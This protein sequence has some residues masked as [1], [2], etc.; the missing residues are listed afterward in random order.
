MLD[1]GFPVR[2]DPSVPWISARVLEPVGVLAHAFTSRRGGTSGGAWASLNL[3]LATGD[4]R[5]TVERNRSRLWEVLRLPRPPLIPRQV[6]GD[7]VVVVEEGNLAACLAE[8]PEADALVTTLRGVP[9]AVL[10]ADCPAVIVCD[11]RTPALGVVHAGWRGTVRAAVWKAL[12]TMF[13]V[14]GTRSEDCVAAVGPSIAPDCYPVGDDV[15]E[16]FARGLP[17]GRDLLAPAG[18]GRWHLDLREGI[19][20]QLLDGRLPAASVAVCSLCTHCEAEWFYS[21]RRDRAGTGRQ[22]AVAMLR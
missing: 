1:P 11:R 5:E 17:Y 15:Y 10:V 7:R 13:E 21:A 3:G 9:L 16:A 20:R 22:A 2:G 19:R 18:P 12:L 6:H 4:D 8:P 14:C